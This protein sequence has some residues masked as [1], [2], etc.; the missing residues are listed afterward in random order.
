MS[1]TCHIH[2]PPRPSELP[3]PPPR[4]ATNPTAQKRPL[5]H[6]PTRTQRN[7]ETKQVTTP[8]PHPSPTQDPASNNAFFPPVSDPFRCVIIK[9][10]DFTGSASSTGE[11][12]FSFTLPSPSCSH[13]LHRPTAPHSDRA[14]PRASKAEGHRHGGGRRWGACCSDVSR[15]ILQADG[16]GRGERWGLTW[17]DEFGMGVW[18]DQGG[19]GR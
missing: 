19:V 6:S 5:Q 14:S 7:K 4:L 16:K 3:N 1:Y 15:S 12:D 13:R 10:Y 8:P 2:P 9:S 18:G 17:D 11:K